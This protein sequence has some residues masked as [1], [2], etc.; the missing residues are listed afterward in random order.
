MDD[1]SLI[2]EQLSK[3]N[4]KNDITELL[5]S[6]LDVDDDV[7]I[8]TEELTQDDIE[9]LLDDLHDHSAHPL[10]YKV[11]NKDEIIKIIKY[12]L[13][14]SN[15]TQNCYLVINDL[16]NNLNGT[17]FNEGVEFDSSDFVNEYLILLY[18]INFKF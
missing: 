5:I 6:I 13:K 15:P 10:N 18:Y 11:E 16:I 12:Y 3:L 4:I 7:D 14:I 2:H 8:Y 1:K 17:L 9:I